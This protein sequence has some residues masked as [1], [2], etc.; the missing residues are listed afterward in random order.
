V[1]FGGFSLG[2]LPHRPEQIASLS[3][4]AEHHVAASHPPEFIDRSDVAYLPGLDSNDRI[5]D[6]T[7]VGLANCARAA[8]ALAGFR[9]DIP[10]ERVIHFY[11]A[12]CGYDGTPATDLGGVEAEVLLWQARYGFDTG[13]QVPLVANVLTIDSSDLNALRTAVVETGAVYLGVDLALADQ[14]TGV[15]DTVGRPG[16][17]TPGSW[18]GHCL[19]LWDYAGVRDVDAVRL[20]TWGIFQTAT[21]RWLRSRLAEAHALLWPQLR[22]V[23]SGP[24]FG[25]VTT[26]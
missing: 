8:A 6:C 26:T 16:D 1:S 18:G 24:P 11:A 4:W 19:L 2:R 10:T 13:G 5:G 23:S 3:P 12:S 20:V 15:W 9:L 25:T 22:T 14:A 17:S 7:A 21:W